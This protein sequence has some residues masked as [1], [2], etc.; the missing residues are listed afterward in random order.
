MSTSN[1]IDNIFDA[2]TMSST[3]GSGVKPPITTYHHLSV[4]WDQTK[5]NL[6]D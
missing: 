1:S 6:M 4:S 2:G 3:D 5:S